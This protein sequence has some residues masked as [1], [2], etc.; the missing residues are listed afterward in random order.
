VQ[1]EVHPGE[2]HEDHRDHLDQRAVEVA[3]A[4]VM[5]REAADGHGAEGVADGIEHDMP[6]PQ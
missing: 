5:G 6:A 4:G 3:D 2:Q 1:R